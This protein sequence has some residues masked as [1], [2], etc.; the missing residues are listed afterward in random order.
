MDALKFNKIAAALLGG[1]LLIMVFGKIADFLVHPNIEVSNS[2]P[3]EVANKAPE[4]AKEDKVIKIEPILMLL[5]SANIEDGQK[6]S[7]KCV[8]C[9]GFDSGGKNKVGPNL[10]NIVNKLQAK[11]DFSYSKALSSL[12]GQWSYQE[13]NKFLYKPK[14]YA[15][16]TKMSYAGLLKVKDRANLIAWLRT[17]SVSP[18]PLP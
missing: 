3:I 17:K 15:K 4:K 8:A 10:Y 14:L 7:K 11:A 12:S 2:Y 9:H 18:A 16:G 5:A 6:I 13:L 1:V